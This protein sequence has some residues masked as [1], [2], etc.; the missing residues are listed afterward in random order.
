M[1]PG[2]WLHIWPNYCHVILLTPNWPEV[3]SLTGSHPSSFS[4][5][6]TVCLFL[7]LTY[8]YISITNSWQNLIF[9]CK[10]RMIW[11]NEK[12]R[13][14]WSR[15]SDLFSAFTW[16]LACSVQ[17]VGGQDHSSRLSVGSRTCQGE[18]LATLHT[19]WRAEIVTV[20]EGDER[21]V[22]VAMHLTSLQ[23]IEPG[24][25]E[26][27]HGWETEC[28]Q[29]LIRQDLGLMEVV[30]GRSNLKWLELMDQLL[31]VT[32]SAYWPDSHNRPCQSQSQTDLLFARNFFTRSGFLFSHPPHNVKG[33]NFS[34]RDLQ[35]NGIVSLLA[36]A[37]GIISSQMNC[38]DWEDWLQAGS[39]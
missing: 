28:N 2:P 10:L 26:E 18:H 8:L 6:S 38:H 36:T 33:T 20:K 15:R 9:L 5:Q 14:Q 32:C 16:R 12:E 37:T 29:V 24:R 1:I 34:F 7:E 4:D 17:S 19:H 30:A 3:P 27:Y 39:H 21:E 11:M 22:T 25:S 35:D 31:K 13:F 23:N